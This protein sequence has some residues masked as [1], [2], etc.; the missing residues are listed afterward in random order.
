MIA[1]LF[2]RIPEFEDDVLAAQASIQEKTREQNPDCDSPQNHF[3]P[4]EFHIHSA[5]EICYA[6][7]ASSA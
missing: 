7:A 2:E 1:D 5:E 4:C 6:S 3:G